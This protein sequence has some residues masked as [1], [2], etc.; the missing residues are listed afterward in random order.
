MKLLLHIGSHKTASTSIQHF[1]ALNRDLLKS[2]GCLYPKN[3]DSAYV[4][5]FLAA[6]LAFGK[7]DLTKRYLQEVRTKAEREK[8]H[9]VIISAESFYAMTWFF[10]DIQGKQYEGDYWQNEARLIKELSKCCEG[11]DEVGVVCYL[12]PQDDYAASL[13]NQFVKNTFGICD[14]FEEFIETA[15]PLFDYKSHIQLWENVFG[16]DFISLRNYSAHKEDLTKDFCD[17]DSDKE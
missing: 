13:Y 12:R 2:Y 6:Q 4:F 17:I 9:T 16:T 8:C 5:N 7:G 1:C 15:R 3:K 10:L 14:S 11:Y